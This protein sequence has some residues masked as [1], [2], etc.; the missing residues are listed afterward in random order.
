VRGKIFRARDASDNPEI[1]FVLR[2]VIDQQNHLVVVETIV[3]KLQL[4]AADELGKKK[5]SIIS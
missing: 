3:G 1:H 5:N 2:A 4:I